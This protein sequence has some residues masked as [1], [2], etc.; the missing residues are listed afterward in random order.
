MP[1]KLQPKPKKQIGPRVDQDLVTEMRVLAVRQ[2]RRFNELIEEAF[3]ELLKKYGER[4]K[5]GN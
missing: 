1:A 4:K 5:E 3:R 2:R